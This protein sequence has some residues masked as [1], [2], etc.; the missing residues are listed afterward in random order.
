MRIEFKNE[1]GNEIV[2][3]VSEVKEGIRVY[4]AGPTSEHENIVTR[5]EACAIQAGL[6]LVLWF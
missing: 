3:D 5:R 2:V 1:L 4:I 6:E